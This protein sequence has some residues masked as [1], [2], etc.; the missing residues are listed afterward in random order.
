MSCKYGKIPVDSTMM[1]IEGKGTALK[2]GVTVLLVAFILWLT[3]TVIGWIYARPFNP[4][5]AMAFMAAGVVFIAFFYAILRGMWM[6]LFMI[7]VGASP[8]IVM[9]IKKVNIP[10]TIEYDDLLSGVGTTT[11]K[12]YL[13]H[14][15]YPL[16]LLLYYITHRRI[17]FPQPYKGLALFAIMWGLLSAITGEIM[18]LS[19]GIY[20]VYVSQINVMFFYI[21]AFSL[22]KT[23]LDVKR[24]ILTSLVFVLMFQITSYL[25]WVV[26]L[27]NSLHPRIVFSPEIDYEYMH[28]LGGYV[29]LS[30]DGINV[31]IAGITLL[32]ILWIYKDFFKELRL[33]RI[34]MIVTLLFQ[35]EILYYGFAS[36]VR[37]GFIG[38]L[39][40][41]FLAIVLIQR[42]TRPRLRSKAFNWGMFFLFIGL[43]Y[44]FVN[45]MVLKRHN[46]GFE[47]NQPRLMVWSNLLKYYVLPHPFFG[48]GPM[49]YHFTYISQLATLFIGRHG[50]NLLLHY[51][52][53]IGIPGAIA[54]WLLYFY[55]LYESIRLYKEGTEKWYRVFAGAAI[56]FFAGWEF[57]VHT[58]GL[59]IAP[60]GLP[61]LQLLFWTIA[62]SVHALR[63]ISKQKS[64]AQT[65]TNGEGNE[66]A[67]SV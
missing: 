22:I 41:L 36:M 17:Y 19:A 50:H 66:T 13:E 3:S 10:I 5:I 51:M 65:L 2:L 18:P 37:G 44:F 20:N 67:L 60:R 24:A 7:I 8:L 64:P 59:Y 6:T 61:T 57:T 21:L 43:A 25:E 34:P 31:N 39:I 63:R 49:A 16:L 62:V 14:I 38:M 29:F 45:L 46:L 23:E 54:L 42:E 11:I 47:E 56:G 12:I 58:T 52:A 26:E 28:T 40:G 55:P 32:T 1:M 53:E 9:L 35:I 30:H 15:L 33:P 27:G 48:I 4:K